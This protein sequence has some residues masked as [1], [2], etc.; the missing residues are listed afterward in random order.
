MAYNKAREEYK[1]KQWKEKEEEQL[2]T[3]GVDE[4]TIQKLRSSDWKDFKAE[5]CYQEHRVS[6]PENPDWEST[7]VD[8][9]DVTD[10]SILLDSISD[11]RLLHI[12]LEAERVTL[13]IILMKV[14][15]FTVQEIAKELKIS[16][17]VIYNRIKRLKKKIK[18]FL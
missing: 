14:M 2:R 13:Q 18:K 1:W 10:I 17:Y 11:E 8:E 9:P 16:E 6:F 4:E 7:D 5:R 15:G 3:L 12:L